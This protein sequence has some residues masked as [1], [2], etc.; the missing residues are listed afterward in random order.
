MEPWAILSTLRR[1]TE[2][3]TLPYLPLMLR[4][5]SDGVALETLLRMDTAKTCV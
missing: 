1:V 3:K 4:K 2:R 5:N